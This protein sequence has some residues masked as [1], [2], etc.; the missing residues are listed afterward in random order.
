MCAAPFVLAFIV[1]F[2]LAQSHPDNMSITRETALALRQTVTITGWLF[3]GAVVVG[4][5][6]GGLLFARARAAGHRTANTW[7]PGSLVLAT[8]AVVLGLISTALTSFWIWAPST[9]GGVIWGP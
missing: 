7:L 2:S 8:L 3:V 9:G 6:G 5:I 1:P 4:A